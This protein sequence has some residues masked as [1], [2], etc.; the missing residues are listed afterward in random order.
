MRRKIVVKTGKVYLAC[1][2]FETDILP[3][4]FLFLP[5]WLTASTK[6]DKRNSW[7]ADSSA[8]LTFCEQ[9]ANR[10]NHAVKKNT[11]PRER[12]EPNRVSIQCLNRLDIE[13]YETS[14]SWLFLRN[15]RSRCNIA[16]RVE[17]RTDLLW[18]ENFANGLRTDLILRKA[19]R[20]EGI[21]DLKHLVCAIVW[22]LSYVSSIKS[23]RSCGRAK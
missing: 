13:W 1:S 18:R 4:S 3:H 5:L 20:A 14:A 9:I 17:K 19:W 8:L 21:V 23:S 16:C 12:F 10:L 11:F 15:K 6:I 22:H 2:Y 7:H